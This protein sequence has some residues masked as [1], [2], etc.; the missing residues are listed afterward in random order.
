[1]LLNI[2]HNSNQW[3][4]YKICKEPSKMGIVEGLASNEIIF[5]YNAI[6]WR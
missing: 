1:M 5:T 2:Y 3:R 6:G 4:N